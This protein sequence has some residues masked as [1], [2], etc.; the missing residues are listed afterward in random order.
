MRFQVVVGRRPILKRSGSFRL[1]TSTKESYNTI[2]FL[3]LVV[4]FTLDG[5]SY[6]YNYCITHTPELVIRNIGFD[7]SICL[8]DR[9]NPAAVSLDGD[10]GAAAA[11]AADDDDEATAEAPPPPATAMRSD[12]STSAAGI[13]FP[14]N[15]GLLEEPPRA[16]LLS[17][18]PSFRASGVVETS[19]PAAARP[20]DLTRLDVLSSRLESVEGRRRRMN[21]GTPVDCRRKS[22]T[23]TK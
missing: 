5:F 19:P 10:T 20:V 9:S 2:H 17:V 1:S 15:D 7:T 14:G 8:C 21:P 12:I 3:F 22:T 16:S 4:F 23:N 11:A 6:N 18:C 13:M